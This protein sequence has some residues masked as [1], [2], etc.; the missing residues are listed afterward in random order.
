MSD[1]TLDLIV[2]TRPNFIKIS[3]IINALDKHNSIKRKI[4]YRLIH[5]GQH[6]DYNMSQVFFDQLKLPKPDIYLNVPKGPPNFQTGEIMKRYETLLQER[7]CNICLVVGD[8]NSTMASAIPAK[9]FNIRVAHVESGLRSGDISMPEEVNR[10]LTDSI[11]DWHFTTS[12]YANTNLKN[13]GVSKNSI[14]FV[15]FIP[16]N[17][18]ILS[19]LGVLLFGSSNAFPNTSS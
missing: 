8:V 6:S 10:I 13:L 19:I 9:K 3:S 14:F 18:I 7:K 2:G 17:S 4:E 5:T 11:T 1:I 12:S 16:V 15:G